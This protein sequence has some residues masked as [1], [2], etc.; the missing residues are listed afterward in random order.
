MSINISIADDHPMII[1]GLKN[2]FADYSHIHV[3][4]TYS[5]GEALM[6]GLKQQIPDVLLLDIQMPGK[7]GDQLVPLL[8]KKYPSL[9][10]LILTNFDSVIY[11]NNLMRHGVAGYLLKTAHEDTL[12]KAIETVRE[13]KE[14]LDPSLKEKI[15]NEVQKKNRTIF[16]QSSLSPREKEVL[17]L[18]VNGNTYKEIAEKLFLSI[19]T[20]DNYK[21]SLLLKLDVKNTAAMVAKALKLGLAE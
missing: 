21:M 15:A 19:H 20:I 11:V 5:D 18:I 7:S 12:I 17:Q 6:Q 2:T 4:A 14:F 3:I 1:K 10:I 13:G 16:S 8:L 9:R